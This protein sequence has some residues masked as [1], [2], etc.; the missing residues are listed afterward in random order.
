[1]TTWALDIRLYRDADQAAVVALNRYGLQA[2]GVPEDADVYAGDLDDISTTYLTGKSVMLVG[3]HDGQ[4]IAMGALRPVQGDSDSCEILRMRVDPNHQ[5]SGYGRAMLEAL[6]A[7]A[8]ALGY[9]RATL[10]TGANQHPA[11]D[12]YQSAG[13]VQIGTET[14]GELTGIR[15]AKEL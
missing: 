6:E 1:M 13:Y 5:G 14:H 9:R 4:V 10:L 2:A 3:E 12:L 15:M 7:H 11:I 8:H